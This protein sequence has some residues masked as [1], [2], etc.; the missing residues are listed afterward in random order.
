MKDVFIR[1]V[2]T[3]WQT[4]LASLIFA[5]PQITESIGAGWVVVKPVL[6]SVGVGALAAGLSAAYNG[7]LKPFAEELKAK[8]E[9]VEK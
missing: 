3:F 1:A 5:M 9:S 6:I 4:A 7:V 8:N 2:K